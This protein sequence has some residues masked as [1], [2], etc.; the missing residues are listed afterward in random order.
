MVLHLFKL[1]LLTGVVLL[2]GCSGQHERTDEDLA[3]MAGGELK[4]TVPVSGKVTIDG[5]VVRDVRIYAYTRES[6]TDEAAQCRSRT[7]GTF[8]FTTHRVCDGMQPGTYRLAFVYFG[9]GVKWED[10]KDLL[11]GKYRNPMTN[12]FPLVVER[13]QPQSELSYELTTKM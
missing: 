3:A 9:E 13:G 6:G 5:K 7:D 10:R 4:E 1:Q 8:C 11:H 2:A 12:D